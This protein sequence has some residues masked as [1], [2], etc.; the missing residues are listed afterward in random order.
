MFEIEFISI[1][2][3]ARCANLLKSFPLEI[4]GCQELSQYLEGLKQRGELSRSDFYFDNVYRANGHNFE[5]YYRSDSKRKIVTI[6]D[7]KL[8]SMEILKSRFSIPDTWND[9]DVINCI[10]QCDKPEKI[11]KTLALIERGINDSYLIGLELGSKATKNAYV[12]RHAQY[13]LDTLEE[14]RL[15]ENRQN[16]RAIATLTK[17]GE[18]IAQEPDEETKVR[19]LIESM[20]NYHPVWQIL[21]AVTEGEKELTDELVKILVFHEIDQ[22]SDTSNRRSQ[23]LKNWVKFISK[24]TGIPIFLNDKSRQ[25][26]I[27]M[28]YAAKLDH[29]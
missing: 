6:I 17:K 22:E 24:F 15:I 19:L 8:R 9:K 2:L 14:L 25:L 26:T 23:T 20:L 16:N 5:L 13:A 18:L 29:E 3:Q 7:I 4:E 11:L 27:P 28:L 12:R 10:P 1:S 21:G